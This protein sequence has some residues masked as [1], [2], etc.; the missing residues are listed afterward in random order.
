MDMSKRVPSTWK[1]DFR[2]EIFCNEVDQE[3]SVD[4]RLSP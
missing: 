4:S 3:N 2:N 1:M